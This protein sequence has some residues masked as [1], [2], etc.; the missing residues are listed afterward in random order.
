MRHKY[1]GSVTT[2]TSTEHSTRAD[3]LAHM[4]SLQQAA[5][6]RPIEY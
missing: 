1:Q 2:M 3:M 5:Y 4:G 6:V